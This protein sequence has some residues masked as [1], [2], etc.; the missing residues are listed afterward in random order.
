MT[1]ATILCPV[2]LTSSS[3]CLLHLQLTKRSQQLHFSALLTFFSAQQP[4][5]STPHPSTAPSPA[6]LTTA[7]PEPSSERIWECLCTRRWPHRAEAFVCDKPSTQFSALLYHHTCKT[8]VRIY[9]PV[10]RSWRIFAECL[11][12]H[13]C[14][15]RGKKEQQSQRER[16]ALQQGQSRWKSVTSFTTTE[17]APF[18]PRQPPAQPHLLFLLFHSDSTHTYR[19]ENLTSLCLITCEQL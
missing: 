8:L 13:M 1:A 10:G 11:L 14:N 17:E 16:K 4:C 6:C 18:A 15:S 5:T 3:Q 19:R 2:S 9:P 12:S 7:I